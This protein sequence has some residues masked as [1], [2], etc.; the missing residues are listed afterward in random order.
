MTQH[1]ILVVGDVMLDKYLQ[2]IVSRI[3]PEAPVPV[4]NIKKEYIHAGGAAN[5]AHNCVTMGAPVMLAGVVGNDAHGAA[6]LQLL[7]EL[8]IENRCV[9]RDCITTTKIRII[10]N[11]QQVTRIDYDGVHH[12][13]TEMLDACAR[14]TGAH[15]ILLSDY[16]K[17]VCSPA[18]CRALIDQSKNH[19]QKVIID[20]KVSDWSQYTGAFMLTPNFK[21]FAAVAGTAAVQD[22]DGSVAEYGMQVRERYQL[23]HLLITRSEK[24]MTLVGKDG[25]THF[26]SQAIEVFDVSGAG[27]TVVA[28]IAASLLEGYGVTDAVIRANL[29][30][31]IAV[32]HIGTYAVKKEELDA[33]FQ[34]HRQAQS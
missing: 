19:G 8:D 2:G 23:D 24:G 16:K 5:V 20:P 9:V 3:S 31:G 17:G 13:E 25:V 12:F 21:E 14:A 26:P 6:L 28:A 11:R 10:G 29:A 7:G 30:A 18:L 34:K 33:V 1:K 15:I 32:S 27:D 4:V 22:T